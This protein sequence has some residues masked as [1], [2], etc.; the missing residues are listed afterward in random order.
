MAKLD[1]IAINESI[2]ENMGV[3]SDFFDLDLRPDN[4]GWTGTCPIHENSDNPVAFRVFNTCSWWCWTRNCADK[5]TSL[6]DLLQLLIQQRYN[7][8][9]DKYYTVQW[10]QDNILNGENILNLPQSVRKR[11][12]YIHVPR[13]FF[14][15]ADAWR[16]TFKCPSENYIKLGFSECVVDK[17]H[18]GECYDRSRRFYNRIVVPVFD[19]QN[20]VI[21]FTGRSM[22]PQ[23][24]KCDLYHSPIAPCPTEYLGTYAKWKHANGFKTSYSLFNS[25]NVK[26]AQEVNL[27]E[28]VGNTLRMI[29]ARAWNTMGIYGNRLKAG[30]ADIL[31]KM[32]VKRITWICD[33][34]PH[35]AG[36]H[37][38]LKAKEQYDKKEQRF[39][40]RIVVPT[41]KDVACLNPSELTAWLKMKDIKT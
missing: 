13:I 18:I 14:D 7:T 9:C 24:I 2:Y 1:W 34:D 29:E 31:E 19:F 27:V 12:Q 37:G 3:I 23:C 33:N 32:G 26:E 30:Q 17:F 4:D 36:L 40:I 41:V 8:K 16:A 39:K 15:D 10:Y 11:S 5:Q 25:W 22:Y 6:I 21:G 20:R 28:S 35:K 38:A